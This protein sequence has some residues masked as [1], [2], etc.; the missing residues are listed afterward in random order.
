MG[1]LGIGLGDHF[2]PPVQIAVV[3]VRNWQ[4]RDKD[5][6]LESVQVQASSLIVLNYADKDPIE[7]LI[8][9]EQDLREVNMQAR[10]VNWNH[11]DFKTLPV[12]HPVKKMSTKMDHHKS[13][14]AS[15]SVNLPDPM[16]TKWLRRVV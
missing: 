2:L 14:W 5:N 16:D 8:Q 15:C 1:F 7:R 6:E 11:L 12:L 3:D 13:H 10:I 9:V 4:K